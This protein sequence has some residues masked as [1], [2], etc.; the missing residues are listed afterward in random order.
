MENQNQEQEKFKVWW[1][2]ESQIGKLMLLGNGTKRS[3]SK[4]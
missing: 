4:Q 3:P 2:E 1:D